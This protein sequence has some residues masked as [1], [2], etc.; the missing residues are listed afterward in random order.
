MKMKYFIL[1]FILLAIMLT[2][3]EEPRKGIDFPSLNDE[4]LINKSQII[5]IESKI[6]GDKK[7]I[8]EE[9]SINTKKGNKVIIAMAINNVLPI[10]KDFRILLESNHDAA[11]IF[12]ENSYNILKIKENDFE[13]LPLILNIPIDTDKDNYIIKIIIEFK[14][15]ENTW[16]QYEEKEIIITLN[17]KNGN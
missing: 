3:C 14:E 6:S 8:L 4:D 17:N 2:G 10:E 5:N 12:S 16:K 7:I 9:D 1:T 13:I 11:G 15:S